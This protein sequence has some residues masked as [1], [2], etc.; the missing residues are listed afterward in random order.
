M[1]VGG[2]LVVTACSGGS[3]R[4]TPSTTARSTPTTAAG[5]GTG[6]VTVDPV[7]VSTN[8]AGAA[9]GGTNPVTVRVSTSPSKTLQVGF[10]EVGVTGTGAQWEAAGWSAVSV[11]TLLVGAPLTNRTVDFEVGG[12]I[13]DP[14]VGGLL[15]VAMLALMRGDPIL[16][17]ITRTGSISPNGTIG[18]VDGIPYAVAAAATAHEQRVL[19]PVG[20]HNSPDASHRLVDV[21]KEGARLGITVTEVDNI[22]DAYKAMTGNDLPRRAPANTVGLDA[23][24]DQKFAAKGE[25]WDARFTAADDDFKKLPPTIRSDLVGVARQADTFRAEA[26]QLGDQGQQGGAFQKRVEAAAFAKAADD[27]GRNLPILLTQGA[28][29]FEA[30]IKA[31]ASISGS[32]DGLLGRLRAFEPAGVSDAGALIA[33]YGDAVDAV[34]FS[35][36][37]RRLLDAAAPTQEQRVAQ[38]T[39]GAVYS[40]LAASLVDAS[41]DVLDVGRDLGGARLGNPIDLTRLAEFFRHAAEAN[42]H[43]FES[44]IIEPVAKHDRISLAAAEQ[45]FAAADS[46]YSLATAGRDVIGALPTSFGTAAG[47]GYAGIGGAVALYNRTAGLMTKYSSLGRVDPKTLGVTGISDEAALDAAISFAQN[48]VAGSVALLQSQHVNPMIVVGDNEIAGVD[49]EGGASDKLHALSE[50]W[51]GYVNGR[52]LAYLGG[53]AGR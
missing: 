4:S 39:E 52:V 18:P 44:S 16:P 45:R 35:L 24:T 21:V 41:A 28:A 42:L 3:H 47:R 23:A 19:I 8:A 40:D 1:L 33:A 29:A 15:T 7:F 12:K 9:V 49:V 6:S 48:Q 2:I 30:Q 34:T 51:D 14:S 11:A 22:Y 38:V 13:E 27:I 25:V 10:T 32:L 37:G 53:F 50:Y 46:D 5:T 36:L 20:Q 17:G 43:A 26:Q 31:T